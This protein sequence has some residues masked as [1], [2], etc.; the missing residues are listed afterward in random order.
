MAFLLQVGFGTGKMYI[1]FMEWK[2]IKGFEGLYEIS[3]TGQ[4]KSLGAGNS[5]DSRTKVV[6]ILKT[7]IKK[8]GYE[9][10]KLCKNGKNYHLTIHRLV[11]LAFIDNP[12]NYREVNH[13]DGVKGN[14]HK[15]NLEWVS[16]SYNQKH[17]FKLGL[18]V[19]IR[20]ENNKQSLKILQYDL[21]GVLLKEW[22][23]IKQVLREK[24]YNTFGI[25]K[26]C[27]NLPRYKT[28]YGF[29]W[30]YKNERTESS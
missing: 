11:A 26:C 16:S 19:P 4:V 9:H 1:R 23:S 22:E 30:Q 20:G 2:Q 29:K 17:A 25:I 3:D 5:T 21:N 13:I 18:Q 15:G 8:S 24:G 10:V 7:R 6:R 12:Q 14:N 28:A 27:K